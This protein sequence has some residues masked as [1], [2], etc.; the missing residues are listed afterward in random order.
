MKRLVL[1]FGLVYSI[2]AV[3]QLPVDTTTQLKNVV[4]EEFTGIYCVYCPDGHKRANEL[5]NNNPGR[6]VLINIH[7]GSFAN[8]SGNDP[9]FRTSFGGA[10]AGQS[11]LVG[12]PAGT[13]NRR[14]FAGLEQG[15]SGTTAMSRGDW[16]AAAAIVLPETS[17]VNVALEGELDVQ[18]NVLTVDVEA[19]FTANGSNVNLLN[20]V[21]LQD[22][23]KGPQTGGASFYPEMIGP[24]GKYIH[25]HMLRHML[26]GQWGDTLHNNSSGDLESKTYTYTLPAN[27]NGVA[28]DPANIQ[29][30]AF[31]TEGQQTVV[32]GDYGPVAF[33]NFAHNN[34]AMMQDVMTDQVVCGS[35]IDG[36]A[37]VRN[38]GSDT[39][40]SIE[41][42]F[43]VNGGT[44]S[45]YTWTGSLPPMSS[46][47]VLLTGASFTDNG[48]NT[49]N[50][51]IGLVNGG[52]D[53]DVTDNTGSN[54]GIS[55]TD[56]ESM[57]D[58]TLEMTQDR[59]G[60]E[61]TWEFVDENGSVI[62]SGGPYSDLSSSGTVLH[63][64]NIPI[65]ALG[66][67]TFHVY[68]SYGDGINSGYGQGNYKILN[69]DGTLVAGSNGQYGSGQSK[70]FQSVSLASIEDLENGGLRIYPN[71]FKGSTHLELNLSKDQL[72]QI[73]MYN[74]LGQ[75]V[76]S[77]SENGVS[78]LN[79]FVLNGNGMS[80]G[81]YF[82]KVR[83]EASE[84]HRTVT[85][86]E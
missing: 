45:S 61:I 42:L 86:T 35:T 22:H 21:L 43:D 18:T 82:V 83:T 20:V 48:N 32:T 49:F 16:A 41:I 57:G 27:I 12:Y 37:T 66:C 80:G 14:N 46:V 33:T 13:V 28:L 78:G 7:T 79:K 56:K 29:I 72:V 3:A 10:I 59:W 77:T 64:H 25:N 85:I 53:Q 75:M 39:L 34:N 74:A 17:Y 19:Y 52:A 47:D 1:L 51:S 84:M 15:A 54:S 58:L 40:T 69:Y 4:L 55:V 24:D 60:S 63:T 30:A 71:P 31:I 8:P 50:A 68:D 36:N 81:I 76:Y 26:T 11:G 9:D 5:K 62:A 70:L 67:Y 2:T 23:V 44:S 73:E 38:F 6:V 65:A